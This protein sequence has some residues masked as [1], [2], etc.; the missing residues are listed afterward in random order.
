MVYGMTYRRDCGSAGKAVILHSEIRDVHR[1]AADVDYFFAKLNKLRK[2]FVRGCFRTLHSEIN[3]SKTTA[4]PPA[5]SRRE[6]AG[7]QQ[8]NINENEQNY[9]H[10]KTN[11]NVRI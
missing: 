4:S 1:L 11:A 8:R 7:R 9:E 3:T 10:D 2:S 6:G 5:L